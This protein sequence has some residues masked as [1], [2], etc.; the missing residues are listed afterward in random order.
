MWTVK[1]RL[2]YE[3]IVNLWDTDE[4]KISCA[5]V[6]IRRIGRA[7]LK[8]TVNVALVDYAQNSFVFPLYSRTYD[9]DDF[10]GACLVEN[11]IDQIGR[12]FKV[13]LL[14]TRRLYKKLVL[15]VIEVKLE[16]KIWGEQVWHTGM[17]GQ[18]FGETL[19]PE[20]N[21]PLDLLAWVHLSF[22]NR[23]DWYWLAKTIDIVTSINSR[24]CVVDD[25]HH[26]CG[27]LA[28]IKSLNRTRINVPV[29]LI[30]TW[31]EAFADNLENKVESDTALARSLCVFVGPQLHYFE[32]V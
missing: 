1:T 21:F 29:A 13:H 28:E 10:Q 3:K 15:G 6:H 8:E 20:I 16:C 23:V 17:L 18:A 32:M 12:N 4:F 14:G 2:V 22:F 24:Y 30:Y 5:K 11:C 7:K 31:F 26:L 19:N 9:G 27:V 25:F